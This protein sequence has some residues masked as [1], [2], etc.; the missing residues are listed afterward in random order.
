[1]NLWRRIKQL[2]VEEKELEKM[3]ES[4]LGKK[5]YKKALA[6]KANVIRDFWINFNLIGLSVSIS[7]TLSR[8]ET[9]TKKFES[10][11]LYFLVADVALIC[12]L[13]IISYKW[14]NAITVQ[15][16]IFLLLLSIF[17]TLIQNNSMELCTKEIE[18]ES[19]ITQKVPFTLLATFTTCMNLFLFR[20]ISR[21]FKMI[22]SL[23][24]VLGLCISL[25][26]RVFGY[27]NLLTSWQT[28]AETAVH[29]IVFYLVFSLTDNFTNNLQM[30]QTI[31]VVELNKEVEQVKLFL[32]EQNEVL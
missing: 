10:W 7:S 13:Q 2:Y 28:T 27:Q 12:V 30:K 32:N 29:I 4:T 14:P 1:M 31:K 21:R 17:A 26:I 24:V 18:N 6:S 22:L 16:S 19:Q 25:S 11:Y 23:L 5:E 20:Q 8:D 9:D 15:L 3:M